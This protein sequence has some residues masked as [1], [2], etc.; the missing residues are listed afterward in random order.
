MAKA[1]LAGHQWPDKVDA[2]STPS[3][4]LGPTYN[5]IFGSIMEISVQDVFLFLATS[6]VRHFSLLGIIGIE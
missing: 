3:K 5:V 4:F 1:R 6:Q 2:K